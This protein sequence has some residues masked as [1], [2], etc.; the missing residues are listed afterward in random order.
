VFQLPTEKRILQNRWLYLFKSQANYNENKKA[1]N[2]KQRHERSI[3]KLR[4]Q[5][6]ESGKENKRMRKNSKFSQNKDNKKQE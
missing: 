5:L 3:R 2:D 4:I 1:A 6:A